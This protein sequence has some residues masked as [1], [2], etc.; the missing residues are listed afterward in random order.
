[1]IAALLAA[2]LIGLEASSLRRWTLTRRGMPMRDTVIAAS[3]EEAETRAFGRWL[4][5]TVPAAR[6][7]RSPAARPVAPS[8]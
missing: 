8:R 3:S 2:W 5:S 1:M 7:P 6:G 4:D